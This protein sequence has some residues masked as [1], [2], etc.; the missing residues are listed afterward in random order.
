MQMAGS[1]PGHDELSYSS[2]CVMR[3]LDPRI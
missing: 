2:H 1:V 3:E